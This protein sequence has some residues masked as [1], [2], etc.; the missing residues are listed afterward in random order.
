MKKLF[1]VIMMLTFAVSL[2]AGDTARKGTAGAEQLLIPVGAR[3]I[4][5]SGAFNSHFS[6][7]E[8]VYYN[9]GGLDRMN[10]TEAM[11]S[12]MSYI[13]DIN[14]SYFAIGTKT[15]FGSIALTYKALDFGDIPVTTTSNPDGT[16]QNYSPSYFVLGLTYSKL[17]TDRV[18][19]GAT[20]SLINEGIMNTS[21]TGWAID[22][23]VQ[24]RFSQNF[25]LGVT[26]KNIGGNMSYTG[27]ELKQKVEVPG[28]ALG[29]GKGVYEVDTEE[30][31]IPSYFDLSLGYTFDFDESNNLSVAGTFRN[32]NTF[33]DYLHMGLEYDF[34]NVVYLR[35]GYSVP[36]EADDYAIYSWTAGAGV[37]FTFADALNLKFDYAF[38]PVSEFPTDNHV[39][40]L[41]IG[42]N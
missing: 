40:T 17:I 29:G 25:S 22:F 2:F 11:F 37:N 41:L 18:S 13:A 42:V 33:E 12:M 1:T 34:M 39:F 16:G 20:F 23:G 27:E 24:Y 26:V 30:F 8:S 38:R 5:T 6:G 4:A 36:M 10:G 19:A 3:S 31:Q 32:N 14:V 7:L 21:A 9:P 15:D 35:G 28:A